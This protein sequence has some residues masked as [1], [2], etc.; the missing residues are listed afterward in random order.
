MFSLSFT[1]QK[2]SFIGLWIYQAMPHILSFNFKLI[3]IMAN[4]ISVTSRKFH[5]SLKYITWP[6]CEVKGTSPKITSDNVIMR[7]PSQ[8]ISF[9]L[10]IKPFMYMPDISLTC[11]YLLASSKCSLGLCKNL[12]FSPVSSLYNALNACKTSYNNWAYCTFVCRKI[13]LLSTLVLQ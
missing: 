9:L 10:I 11:L 3:N 13:C 2:I 1:V 5:C 7:Q 4:H 12:W 6:S 8:L